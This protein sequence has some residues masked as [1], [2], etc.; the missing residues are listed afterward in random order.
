ML[1]S[2]GPQTVPYSLFLKLLR[3]GDIAKA[4]VDPD[5]IVSQLKPGVSLADTTRLEAAAP[6]PS[7]TAGPASVSPPSAAAARSSEPARARPGL[8]PR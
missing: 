6:S 2:T 3:A 8:H 7:A 5:R 4:E 1:R